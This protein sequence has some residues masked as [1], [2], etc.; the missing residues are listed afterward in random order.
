MAQKKKASSRLSNAEK[1]MLARR[2]AG[3]LKRAK[4]LAA[5]KKAAAADTRNVI[6]KHNDAAIAHHGLDKEVHVAQPILVLDPAA[7]TQYLKDQ[8][9][10]RE[11][12]M[13]HAGDA[14]GYTLPQNT[15]AS[16]KSKTAVEMILDRLAFLASQTDRIGANLS[17]FQERVGGTAFA[18][19][20]QKVSDSAAAPTPAPAGSLIEVEH[21]LAYLERNVNAL[22]EKVSK[23]D[24]LG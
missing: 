8:M 19:G 15:V 24:R 20:D 3:Q 14:A 22:G 17:M 12:G 11:T 4:T 13:C 21:L 1:E 10:N 6:E 23:L 2:A 7:T 18:Y 9:A 5:K 16:A